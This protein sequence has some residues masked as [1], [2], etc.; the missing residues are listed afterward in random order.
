[1]F[2]FVKNAQEKSPFKGTKN[3]LKNKKRAQISR[4]RKT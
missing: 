4:A 3:R 2:I 1:M